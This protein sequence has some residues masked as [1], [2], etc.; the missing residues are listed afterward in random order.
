MLGEGARAT[1]SLKLYAARMRGRTSWAEAS[2]SKKGSTPSSSPSRSSSYQLSMGMPFSSWYPNACAAQLIFGICL[3]PGLSLYAPAGK[4]W[5]CHVARH[6]CLQLQWKRP[7]NSF[8]HDSHA[9]AVPRMWSQVDYNNCSCATVLTDCA[10][11][12]Q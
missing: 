6:D 11:V 5:R 3:P 4:C 1:R 7:K 9:C 10:S 12:L 2:S 8:H